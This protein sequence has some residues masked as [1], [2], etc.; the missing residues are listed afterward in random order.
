[1][2]RRP[3]R[4]TRTD[5]LFPYTTLFRSIGAE[6]VAAFLHGEKGR[7]TLA[8]TFRKRI[9]LRDRRHVGI[10]RAAFTCL[11]DQFRQAVISLR[12]DDD[13][14]RGPA[15]DDF[16]ALRLGDAPGD[17]HPASGV[18]LLPPSVFGIKDRKP[19]GMGK[20]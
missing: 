15:P 5:T 17:H 18:V 16:L 20:R 1:M 13:I 9:E 10:Y 14:D 2:I 6:L 4:S 7:R 3:P 19:A 12:S 11:A 8:A